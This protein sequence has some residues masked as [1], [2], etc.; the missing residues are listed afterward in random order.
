MVLAPTVTSHGAVFDTVPAP[1]PEFPAEHTTVTPRLTAWNDPMAT[2]SRRYPAGAPPSDTESTSTPSWMAAS[3]AAMMSASKHSLPF[4]GSQ[5]TLYAATCAPGA[6]PFA[7][8][9]P[10]PNRLAPGTNRPAA[11]D[12][13]CVPW[14]SVSLVLAGF[15]A[16]PTVDRYPLLKYL[17]PISFLH[18]IRTNFIHLIN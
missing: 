18:Q 8:P 4:T 7:V 14:P 5:H 13:V 9:L 2:P 1:G 3:N 12:S 16:C 6:P 10:Y 11:V 17:A 15:A